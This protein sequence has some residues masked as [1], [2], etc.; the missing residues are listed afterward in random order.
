M[1]KIKEVQ[2]IL[3]NHALPTD[4]GGFIRDSLDGSKFNKI[5]Q[6]IVR[7]FAIPHVVFSEAE[8]CGNFT[9]MEGLTS[10]TICA[11][12]GKEKWQHKHN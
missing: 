7:L 2:Q 8:L 1:D 9:P 6:D 12:C 3:N 10:G 11:N 4:N 5:A